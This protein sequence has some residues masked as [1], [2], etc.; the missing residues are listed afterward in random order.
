LNKNHI[1]QEEIHW[2]REIKAKEVEI[3]GLKQHYLSE[4]NKKVTEM[5]LQ[6]N[7]EQAEKAN[8]IEQLKSSPADEKEVNTS[9]DNSAHVEIS[10]VCLKEQISASTNGSSVAVDT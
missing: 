8:L 10:D 3:E 9:N 6:L 4:L 1:E 5:Q 2:R 7:A